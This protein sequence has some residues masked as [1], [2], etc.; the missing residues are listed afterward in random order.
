[1]HIGISLPIRELGNDI[2][3]IKAF[4]QAAE[5]LGLSASEIG[6]LHDRGIIAGP[7]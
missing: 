2:G 1:M 5:D 6:E 3:A 7:D 4:A